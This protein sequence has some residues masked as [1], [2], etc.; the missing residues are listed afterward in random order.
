MDL[1]DKKDPEIHFMDLAQLKQ[2]SSA[3]TFVSELQRVAV[4][5]SDISKSRLIML[6]TE[7]PTY[8][9]RVWVEAYMPITLQDAISRT[10]YLQNFVPKRK[11]PQNPPTRQKTSKIQFPRRNT[12]MRRHNEI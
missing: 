1:F 3:E 12:W 6:F 5:V 11:P 2:T 8:P 10:Q 4:M 7:A 9:L